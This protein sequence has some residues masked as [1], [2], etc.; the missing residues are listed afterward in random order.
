MSGTGPY[1]WTI[2]RRF[3]LAAERLGINAKRTTL[4][5][6]LFQRPPQAGEQL[7]LI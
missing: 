4:A 7:T 1:A 2:G 5:T 6:D 3:Q